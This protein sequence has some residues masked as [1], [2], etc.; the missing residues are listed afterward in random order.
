M[1]RRPLTFPLDPR[2]STKTYTLF[3]SKH[4]QKVKNTIIHKLLQLL[5]RHVIKIIN[6]INNEMNWL[7]GESWFQ[8]SVWE[9]HWRRLGKKCFLLKAIFIYISL[10]DNVIQWATIDWNIHK[11]YYR[12]GLYIYIYIYI[13][14]YLQIIKQLYKYN[15][16]MSIY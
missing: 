2:L 16:S 9:T 15:F 13:H 7:E 8:V 1:N 3:F 11:L 5:E 14:V 6:L 12:D 4:C 10:S